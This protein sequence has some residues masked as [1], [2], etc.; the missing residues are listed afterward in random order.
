MPGWSGHEIGTR[1]SL[2]YQ[3][4]IQRLF[5]KTFVRLF[6]MAEL[7]EE[8]H[9]TGNSYVANSAD[10]NLATDIGSEVLQLTRAVVKHH[11]FPEQQ[12]HK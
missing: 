8:I 2:Q 9:D 1:V 11:L 3:L 5:A 7:L 10:K 4:L 6:K 12:C